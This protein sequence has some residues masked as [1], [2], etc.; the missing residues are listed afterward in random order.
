METSAPCHLHCRGLG[1]TQHIHRGGK[2][3]CGTMMCYKGHRNLM[4]FANGLRY[5]SQCH[6]NKDIGGEGGR[7][8]I[9]TKTI[10]QLVS[11]NYLFMLHLFQ[12]ILSFIKNQLVS[13][14][15]TKTTS[16]QRKIKLNFI[17]TKIFMLQRTPSRK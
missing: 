9:K 12:G 6:Q 4:Q 8:D 17:K 7:E 5:N 3:T 10:M 16:N 2:R 11:N 13:Q 15:D 14:Y 1:T